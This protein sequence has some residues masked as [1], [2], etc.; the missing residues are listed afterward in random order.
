M[1]HIE[2]ASRTDAD[3]LRYRFVGKVPTR[4]DADT[5]IE[6]LCEKYSTVLVNLWV[7][8]DP[9]EDF[10]LVAQYDGFHS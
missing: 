8:T 9:Q 10:E 4:A 1:Y 5:A 3:D 7:E 2:L 6:A